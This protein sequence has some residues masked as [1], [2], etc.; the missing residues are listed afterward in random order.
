MYTYSKNKP[1]A[2]IYPTKAGRKKASPNTKDRSISMKILVR[3]IAVVITLSF[4]SHTQAQTFSTR[5]VLENWQISGIISYIS[6]APNA[7]SLGLSNNQNVTGGGDGAR[8]VLTCDPSHNAPHSFSHWFNAGCVETPLAGSVPTAANPNGLNYS[9]G[10]GVFAPKV[11]FFL[12][13]DTNFD[14]ALFKNVPPKENFR[15]Q[16]RVEAYNT[17]NHSEFNGV[18]NTATFA[19]ANSQSNPQTQAIFGQFSSTLNPRLMQLALR[20]DF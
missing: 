9:T 19:N 6:G 10:S 17:F 8:V 5:A 15:L 18:N 12:P 2:V 11:Q 13:G 14:T 7:I 4:F 3:L 1:P 20:I 16:L